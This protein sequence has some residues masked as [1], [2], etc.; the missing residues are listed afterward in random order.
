MRANVQERYKGVPEPTLEEINAEI[1]RVRNERR[2][3]LAR[4]R[5]A[6]GVK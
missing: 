5:E 6:A 3:R 4:E 2:E 1:A